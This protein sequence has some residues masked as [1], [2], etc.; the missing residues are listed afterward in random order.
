VVLKYYSNI[1][2]EP[3]INEPARP[4]ALPRTNELNH[5]INTQVLRKW[6]AGMRRPLDGSLNEARFTVSLR[7]GPC[8][9]NLSFLL[10]AW[11]IGIF[12]H[13]SYTSHPFP[14]REMNQCILHEV[15]EIIE[16]YMWC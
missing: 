11:A 6:G 12:H 3:L 1:A 15:G 14:I 2:V 8:P 5:S 13:I 16:M 7:E 9:N 4:S 10:E